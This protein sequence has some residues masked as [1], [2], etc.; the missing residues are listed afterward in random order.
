MTTFLAFV[1]PFAVHSIVV[2]ALG[3]TSASISPVSARVMWNVSALLSECI[4]LLLL[5]KVFR[6]KTIAIAVIYLPVMYAA[7][8]LYSFVLNGIV[9]G[10]SL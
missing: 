9:L 2:L 1:V 3:Q 7:L 10:D 5:A 8:F 6:G 4:G